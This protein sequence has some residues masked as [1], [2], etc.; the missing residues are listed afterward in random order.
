MESRFLF[1]NLKS[2]FIHRRLFTIKRFSTFLFLLS[3]PGMP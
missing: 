2:L 1:L 3:V